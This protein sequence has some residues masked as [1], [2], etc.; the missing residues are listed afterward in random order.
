MMPSHGPAAP[1]ARTVVEHALIYGSPATVAEKM[2]QIKAIGVGGVIMAFRLGPMR[3]DD[4]ATS[5]RLFM[6]EVAPQFRRGDS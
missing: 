1:P 2:A 5:L 6:T 3:Y 4:A